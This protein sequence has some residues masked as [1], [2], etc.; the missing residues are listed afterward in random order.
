MS[1]PRIMIV[2]DEFLV[3]SDIKNTLEEQDYEVPA[4]ASSAEEAVKQAGELNPDLVLMDIILKGE[5]DGIEAAGEIQSR[6]GI[7]IVFL[8]AYADK[9]ELEK[10]KK[11]KPFGYLVKPF[12]PDN[13]RAVIEI[14]LLRSAAERRR[15]EFFFKLQEL[16][17][18][19]DDLD[20]SLF[21]CLCCKT[22]RIRKDRR[23]RVEEYLRKNSVVNIKHRICIKC[24]KKRNR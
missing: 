3:A 6:F 15:E 7:P 2:E 21:I 24:A 13:L 12:Y 9:R 23:E 22:I 18:R 4:I 10:A 16:T 11:T 5:M 19:R 20:D 17:A 14:A 8:T 1:K